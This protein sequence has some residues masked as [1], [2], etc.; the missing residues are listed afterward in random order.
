MS[1]WWHWNKLIW[2]VG[3]AVFVLFMVGFCIF[4]KKD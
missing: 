3:T 4:S 1:T 2:L